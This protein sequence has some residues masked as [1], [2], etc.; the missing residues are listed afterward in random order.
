[1][2]V[3]ILA[4]V[5]GII[6][7]VVLQRQSTQR[8]VVEREVRGYKSRHFERGVREVV[9]AWT[10]TLA[11]QPV[12]KLVDADGHALDLAMPDGSYAAVYLFDG[13]GSIVTDPAGMTEQEKADA[14]GILQQLRLIGGETPKPSWVRPVGPVAVC[15]ANADPEVIESVAAY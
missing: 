7:A 13:Q 11:G 1:P 5:S 12:D 10:D 14:W 8:Q 3:L 4:L 6:A 15:I 2:V 9:S